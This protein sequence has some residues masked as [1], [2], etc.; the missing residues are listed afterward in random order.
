MRYIFRGLQWI[1]II[2]NLLFWSGTFIYGLKFSLFIQVVYLL[3]AMFLTSAISCF[4]LL[5]LEFF[6]Q[7]SVCGI[8]NTI[9]KSKQEI[10]KVFS[11]KT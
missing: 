7:W 11:K 4:P 6:Y 8:K 1:I 9:E 3:Y 5:T 10:L 2:L